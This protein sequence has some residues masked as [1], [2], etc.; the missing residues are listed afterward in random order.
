MFTHGTIFHDTV[1]VSGNNFDIKTL[2][3][4]ASAIAPSDMSHFGMATRAKYF[5]EFT[6]D[7][8]AARISSLV[9][10]SAKSVEMRYLNDG[11]RMEATHTTWID[12]RR[13]ASVQTGRYIRKITRDSRARF[14]TDSVRKML[15]LALSCKGSEY[16]ERIENAHREAPF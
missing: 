7:G 13:L 3:R 5:L 12:R 1:P 8:T 11:K 2:M 15:G 10:V 4:Q 6:H 16:V 14:G 9:L